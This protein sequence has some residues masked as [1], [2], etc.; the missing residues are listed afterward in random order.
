MSRTHA[1]ITTLVL[2]MLQDT[3]ASTYGSAETVYWIAESLKEFSY[4]DSHI[5][6]AVFKIESR[7]GND[8]AGTASKL[9]DTTKSQFVDADATEEKVIY[10]T[11]DK[12]WAVT[13]DKDS[14][15]VLGLSADIMASGEG[16][17]IF[18]KR[19]WNNKQIYIGDATDYLWIDSVEYP[20]GNKRNHKVYGDVLEIDVGTVADSDPTPT[21]L[22]DV[23]VL[24]RFALPHTLTSLVV[25]AGTVHT[26]AN[27]GATSMIVKGFTDNEV[28]GLGDEF[29]IAD[30]KTTY[31]VTLG[32][33][34]TNQATTGK[35]IY[36]YPPLESAATA[37][38]VVTFVKSTLRPQHEE[39]F[40]H[41]VAA[42]AVLSDNINYI[43]AI[44]K[45]GP[46]VYSKYRDWGE[47][48][49]EEVL[50]KLDRIS[51]PKTKKRYPTA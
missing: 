12:T 29:H 44:N 33:T 43:N 24:A 51:I 6:D 26:T 18:N 8:T 11:M 34:M 39:L 41:L 4:Y 37:T 42:R 17:K 30:Q 40:C 47:R 35:I 22:G 5:V 20:I 48:K 10:N 2:Q 50:T 1:Q 21:T 36:F 27:I 45:G 38:D 9:T 16:Y 49:L 15:S 25:L 32:V 31:T 46:E 7:T 23:N 3:G 19:C 14:S 13:E 28:A